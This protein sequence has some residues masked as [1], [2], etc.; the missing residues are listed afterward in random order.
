MAQDSS[1]GSTNPIHRRASAAPVVA[2]YHR[3]FGA[4]YHGG[5]VH[6]RGFV[7]GLRRATSVE[8]VAP[9]E[10]PKVGTRAE[11]GRSSP[12]MVGFE[13][14]LSALA[15]EVRFIMRDARRA[16][17]E[18]CRVIVSFDVY[19]AGLAAVWSWIRRVPFVYYPQDSNADVTRTWRESKYRGAVLFR[20]TRAPLDRL[21]TH[22]AQIVIA[23]SQAVRATLAAAGVPSSKLRVCTLKRAPSAPDPASVA[24]WRAEL[25]LDRRLGAVFVGSFQYAPNVRAFEFL[26]T[27]VAPK[28]KDSD[29][30]VLF[31][32]AGLDSE[33]Y[34][35]SGGP[36][37]RVLGTVPDLAGLLDSC[38][39][40]LAPM[41]S[42]GGTSGKIVDYVLH[43]LRVLATEEAARGI[44][45]IEAITISSKAEFASH[46]RALCVQLRADGADAEHLALNPSFL[47]QYTGLEDLEQI[48]LEIASMTPP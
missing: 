15:E 37:V 10:R 36:N 16:P 17:A 32:V 12:L 7:E 34:I 23:P 47:R 31:V 11:T 5:S 48:A 29:P 43:G 27:D 44:E 18:R 1:T 2:L 30:D 4:R 20:W 14:L 13:Y 39:V 38:D 35:G 42:T 21:G 40:G 41:D 8:V 33:P 46:L 22:V 45:P 24:K 6:F 3:A 28:L 25:A 9:G 19:V 26:C